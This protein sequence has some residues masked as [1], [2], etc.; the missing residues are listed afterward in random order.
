MLYVLI[1]LVSGSFGGNGWSGDYFGVGSR[2][3][4]PIRRGRNAVIVTKE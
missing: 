3:R 2:S 4:V 1:A